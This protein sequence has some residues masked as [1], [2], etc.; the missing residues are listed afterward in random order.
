MLKMLSLTLA[1]TV[2]LA[3]CVS[4]S[5]KELKGTS[6]LSEIY[7]IKNMLLNGD[8]QQAAFFSPNTPLFWTPQYFKDAEKSQAEVLSNFLLDNGLLTMKAPAQLYYTCADITPI[9]ADEFDLSFRS[10]VQQGRLTCSVVYR[11]HRYYGITKKILTK[12]FTP[13]ANMAN[14]HIRFKLKDKPTYGYLQIHF[15][16]TGKDGRAQLTDVKLCPVPPAENTNIRSV[17][18]GQSPL[19]GIGITNN[20]SFYERQAALYLR[21]YL[22]VSFGKYYPIFIDGKR[23]LATT[24]NLILIGS[25]FGSPTTKEEVRKGGFAILPEKDNLIITGQPGN[26]DGTIQG[27]FALLRSLGIE[28]FAMGDF[29]KPTTATLQL[30]PQLDNPAFE[31]RR[32]LGESRMTCCALGESHR[33]LFNEGGGELGTWL[34]GYCH[35]TGILLNPY[36]YFKDYPE[37]YALNPT[38]KKRTWAAVTNHN[39]TSTMFTQLCISNPE[40][41]KAVTKNTIRWIDECPDMANFAFCF[42]D[43]YGPSNWCACENCKKYAVN[44]TDRWLKFINKV[45][46]KVHEKYPDVIISFLT[47]AETWDESPQHVKPAKNVAVEYCMSFKEWGC[48]NHY[49]CKTNIM[50]GGPNHF[51]KWHKDYKG[52]RQ[53]VGLYGPEMPSGM[54]YPWA[55]KLRDFKKMDIKS[56]VN[57]GWDLSWNDYLRQYVLA[58]LAWNP[59]R[60]VDELIDKFCEFY[61]KN[62][63]RYV[64]AYIKM[65]EKRDADRA[66]IY[67][68]PPLVDY[69]FLHD[70]EKQLSQ[71]I[72]AT[73]DNAIRFNIEQELFK[74]RHLY[75]NNFNKSTGLRGENLKEFS[76]TLAAVLHDCPKFK[77]K[78]LKFNTSFR[79]YINMVALMDIGDTTPW[80]ESPVLKAFLADPEGTVGKEAKMCEKI[81]NG[82]KFNIN[83]LAGGDSYSNLKGKKFCRIIRRKS[84]PASKTQGIFELDSIPAGKTAYIEVEG[85]DD[86]KEKRTANMAVY[87]NGKF[88]THHMPNHFKKDKWS[89][90]RIPIKTELLKKGNNSILIRNT[91]K[92]PQNEFMAEMGEGTV[93]VD[94]F[95]GWFALAGMELIF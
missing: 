95:W 7:T 16:V 55:R 85:L 22:Y 53:Q 31:W 63:G 15:E 74:V 56:V 62:A 92:D 38:L 19:S 24:K 25:E 78:Y 17:M 66:S 2:I 6:E 27:V 52:A 9:A 50:T 5:K 21:K 46:E 77:V 82:I 13:N 67:P 4:N 34:M 73:H 79:D 91:T 26:D 61:Y 20:S 40:T 39:S 60:D 94:Y 49:N 59:D 1:L 32:I 69:K 35:P 71:A 30:K 23:T 11:T 88:V 8:F 44:D 43:R 12:T 54:L 58:Q 86:D 10:D 36:I 14:Q 70:A 51:L 72:A 42:G 18:L 68:H 76:R 89:K 29:S 75:I 83:A 65:V 28:F 45:A 3:G 41:L 64:A 47:Y 87:I 90:V 48:K 81:D 57:Y 33:R 80:T 37:Y 93:S 84:S